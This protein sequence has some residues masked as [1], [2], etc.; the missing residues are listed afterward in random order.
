MLRFELNCH[1][2]TMRILIAEDD[3]VSRTILHRTIQKFGHECLVAKDGVQA[4]ELFQGTT[5]DI[6]ISDWMMPN[7]DGVELCRRIRAT[8][9]EDYV[10]F[11]FLT[12]QSDKEF[13][14][15][16]MRA[17]ADDYLTKP[18]DADE[19]QVR[20]IAATRI[21]SLH[22]QLAHQK[23]ELERLNQQ[24]FRQARRDPLTQLRNR[25]QLWEDLETLRSRVERYGH[26]YCIALCDV[27]CFKRYNDSYGHPAG[28]QVLRAVADTIAQHC[29]GGD[30]AYR[31]GGEEFLIIL[32]EQSLASA[33]IAV[34]SL[35]RAVEGLAIP[36][37]ART[38]SGVVTISAG[39]AALLPGETKPA[40]LVLQEADTALYHAKESGR[41]RVAIYEMSAAKTMDPGRGTIHD[42]G[43]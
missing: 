36:H 41:N 13:L 27:D 29:R 43:T 39:V 20:L 1:R 35:R 23:Q 31:Y 32:P 3:R 16:G 12:A 19:L 37:Q 8:S 5:V 15:M 24:L 14:L 28:D 34:D 7:V 30:T 38:P 6:V 26:R 18:L 22:Q 25:L 33:M 10:Y 42:Q 17:G 40:D 9:S 11:I 21:T 2:N 4:W